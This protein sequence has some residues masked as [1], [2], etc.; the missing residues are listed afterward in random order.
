MTRDR[1]KLMHLLLFIVLLAALLLATGTI[2]AHVSS[3]NAQ[4]EIAASDMSD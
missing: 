2:I 4:P 1:R 3:Q